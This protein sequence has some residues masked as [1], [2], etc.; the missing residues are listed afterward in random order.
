LN[1]RAAARMPDFKNWIAALFSE[2]SGPAFTVEG[3]N[4]R[5]MIINVALIAASSFTLA[6]LL[7][8]FYLKIQVE[9]IAVVYIS[10][11][12]VFIMGVAVLRTQLSFFAP[13]LIPLTLLAVNC[14]LFLRQGFDDGFSSLW[15]FVILPLIYFTA[16]KKFGF[17]ISS[18]IFAASL[19]FLFFP[20]FSVYRY[21]AAK[22]SRIITVYI[23]LFVMAHIYEFAR[24][25][26]EKKL[27]NL[28]SLLKAERDEFA[29]MKNSLKT[30]LFLMDKEL[31]IQDHY[32][33]L[34][35]D[36]LGVTGLSGKK[37][38]DLLA[39]SLTSAEISTVIDFF[40]MVRERS[41]DPDMLND[42]N[43]LHELKYIRNGGG[44]V[45][46][47]HCMFTPIERTSGETVIMCNIEDITAKIELQKQF[48]REEVKHQEEINTLFEVLQIDP[49][50]FNDFIEDT[51][52]EFE[53][54]N[55]ILKNAR[56][57]SKETLVTI[58][59]S[60]HAIKANAIILGLNNYSQKLHD[61]E[62]YTKD[63][64]TKA[65]VNF[66]DMLS[67][68]IRIESVME[69]KDNF[70]KSVDRIK[71]FS[72]DGVKKSPI[73]ILIESLNRTAERSAA[74]IGK[75]VRMDSGGIDPAALE[76]APRRL[77]KE[78][79]LQLVRNAVFH[80]IESPDERLS[81]GKKDTG[82]IAVSIN[83]EG[84][85]VHIRLRDD[86]KGLD[87]EKIKQRAEK[88]HLIRKNENIEDK[89][90]IYQA[91]FMPGFSTAGSEGMY[92][93]RGVGLDLVRARIKDHNG[94]IKIQTEAGK[95]SIFHIFLP[96]QNTE[97]DTKDNE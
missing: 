64:Q 18:A 67:L 68:T 4:R 16:G 93:G 75:K 40:K 65:E 79:L 77:V 10:V 17:I 61:I 27:Q 60:I 62:S 13:A 73:D 33:R 57:S 66:D 89:N 24:A 91:I 56:I 42:I 94:T 47:L 92:A 28:N 83:I 8:M 76:R 36:T 41:F 1:R 21:S 20:R 12:V 22:V 52:Y 43:P 82:L 63:L 11:S 37:F 84:E 6:W 97:E 44:L 49:G 14:V 53:T 19:F 39:S 9:Q 50:V 7:L 5:Y 80:G 34:L 88:M 70:K 30:S 96:L 95:G 46:T 90:R 87:F 29:I 54:I 48:Q 26:K 23:L 32:S 3:D 72:I 81:L 69:D 55:E 59:Q 31:I 78:V 45:K 25:L 86:G 71:S 58:F 85:R 74:G 51:E 35:E 15:I 38:T 2:Y